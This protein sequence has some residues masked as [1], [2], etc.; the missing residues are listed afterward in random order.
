MRFSVLGNVVEL[1][2]R[3]AAAFP[4]LECRPI[5]EDSLRVESAEPVR[6]GPLVRLL[7]DQGAE[8]SEARKI[9]PSLE[10]VFVQVTGIEAGAMKQEK[11]K[12]MGGGA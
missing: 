10:D 12:R 7:E 2:D 11:E 9:V 5:A 1:C 3:I 6:V 4:N 8:V